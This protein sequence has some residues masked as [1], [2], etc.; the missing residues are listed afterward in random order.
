MRRSRLS[1]Q[2]RTWWANLEATSS[3][4][5]PIFAARVGYIQHLD[6]AALSEVAE[7]AG[8][9][10]YVDRRPARSWTL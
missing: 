8:G 9:A 6:I 1:L 7:A 5:H 3:G 2:A 10:V 4:C